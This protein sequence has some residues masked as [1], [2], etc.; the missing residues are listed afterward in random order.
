MRFAIPSNDSRI[1]DLV[2]ALDRDGTPAAQTWRLV[3]EAAERLG[4][5]RP[6][7]EHVRRLVR[8][9]RLRREARYARRR[10]AAGVILAGGSPYVVRI[11]EA[12]ER[13]EEAQREERLVTLRHKALEDEGLGEDEP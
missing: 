3:G 4:L 1:V 10:A 13:L 11:S 7:Y 6:S 12:L 5:R 8:R 9:E 2:V